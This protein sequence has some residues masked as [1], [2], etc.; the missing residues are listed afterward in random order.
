MSMNNCFCIFFRFWCHLEWL[1][2]F[3]LL[4]SLLRFSHRW[5]YFEFT[6]VP[7]QHS[8][9][10]SKPIKL[11]QTIFPLVGAFLMCR[12]TISASC[13]APRWAN[14]SWEKMTANITTFNFSL[15]CIVLKFFCFET[16]YWIQIHEFLTVFSKSN[17]L[18]LAT[19][20]YLGVEH[21][22]MYFKW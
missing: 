19:L 4:L 16:F 6:P 21:W 9:V 15:W 20:I 18:K 13:L 5:R 3:M 1:V 12:S 2:L 14:A 22:Y 8:A 11:C 10:F 7:R 17:G